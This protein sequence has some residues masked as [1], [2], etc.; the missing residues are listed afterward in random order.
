MYKVVNEYMTSVAECSSDNIKNNKPRKP[1]QILYKIKY[2][3]EQ[4]K[5]FQLEQ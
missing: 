5:Q 4:D 2:L 3:P 1:M